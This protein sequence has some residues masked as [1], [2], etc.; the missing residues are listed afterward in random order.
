VDVEEPGYQA[1]TSQ[2][3]TMI[4]RPAI[5]VLSDYY[6]PGYKAG[7]PIRTLSNIVDH[8]GDR[9]EFSVVTR[10]RDLGDREAY[11]E[12]DISAIN[13]NGTARIRFL[14]PSGLTFF[15]L[16]RIIASFRHD[17]LYLNS[18]FSPCFTIKPL[19]LRRIGLVPKR[20]VIV[21]PRGEFSPGALHIK[22]I[23][24]GVYIH[25]AKCLDLYKNVVWQASSQYEAEDIRKHWGLDARITVAPDLV[26]ISNPALN[27]RRSTK[28]AGSL[29]VVFL[30]R[31]SPM[32]NL[33]FALRC[34]D[35]IKGDL[36]LD[37]FGPLE[38]QEYWIKCQNIIAALPDNVT[39]NYHGELP[40]HRVADVLSEYDLFFLPSH[41]ENF[42]HV[43]IEAMSAGCPVL[44]S[45]RT[46]WRDLLQ[47]GVGW[48]VP[49]EK[50][51]VFQQ[52]LQSC[53]DMDEDMLKAWSMRARAYGGSS[54][55]NRKA[56]E[57]NCFLFDSVLDAP[58]ARSQEKKTN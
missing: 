24:K 47:T 25:W 11:N 31:I 43:I 5:L 55:R 41:G 50:L 35:G 57:M 29:R 38:D 4:T 8:L 56:L 7:G 10:D 36:H 3:Y 46:P 14:P 16:R 37:I 34:L 30:S 20:P 54:E 45:D 22:G 53:I 1:K 6:L 17:I 42:G 19:L 18:F 21:A 23:K 40:H 15:A 33:D 39:V 52:I 12:N 44:I 2:L 9:Y 51:K 28:M 32:K 49:L 13:Q 48:D 58:I 26:G 27:S